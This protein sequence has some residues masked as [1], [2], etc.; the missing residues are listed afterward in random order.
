M[1]GCAATNVRSAR[2]GLEATSGVSSDRSWAAIRATS[3]AR[4]GWNVQ[5]TSWW[6]SDVSVPTVV[7]P[8]DG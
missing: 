1:P 4:K 6:T 2:S 5:A 8:P 3:S 7:G